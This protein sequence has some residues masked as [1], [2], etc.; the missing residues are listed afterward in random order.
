MCASRK[1]TEGNYS[2]GYEILWKSFKTAHSERIDMPEF[3]AC[4][5]AR[6]QS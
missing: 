6:R 4:Y 3:L 5:E 1:C 2:G